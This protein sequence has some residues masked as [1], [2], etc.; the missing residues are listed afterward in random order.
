MAHCG[1]GPFSVMFLPA[2]FSALRYFVLGLIVESGHEDPFLFEFPFVQSYFSSFS[3]FHS[4][5]SSL[6]VIVSRLA[7]TGMV[8]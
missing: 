2:L 1:I 6:M 4:I 7:L 8:T 5:V 3:R